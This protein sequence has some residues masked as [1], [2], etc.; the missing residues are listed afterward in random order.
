[1]NRVI[2]SRRPDASTGRVLACLLGIMV[3]TATGAV[4]AE[5]APKPN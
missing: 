3:L 2:K 4:G 5:P 1:M